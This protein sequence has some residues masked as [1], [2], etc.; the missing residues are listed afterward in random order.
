[1]F[2]ILYKNAL[3]DMTYPVITLG[4]TIFLA[5]SNPTFEAVTN[6]CDLHVGELLTVQIVGSHIPHF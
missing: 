2:Q 4:L 6:C 3:Y 1:M 5:L